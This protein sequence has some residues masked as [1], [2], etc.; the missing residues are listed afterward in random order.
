MVHLTKQEITQMKI[1][2][3]EKEIRDTPKHK[4]TEHHLGRLRARLSQLKDQEMEAGSKKGGGVGYSVKKQGD[5]TVVLV[6]SPSVGK[7]TLLNKLTNAKSKIA[8]YAFTTVTVIPGMMEY[9]EAKIQILDV[10]GL[11]EGAEAGKG[12]G[13]EV[14]SV[15]RNSDLLIILCDV[16]KTSS[17]DSITDSL[18]KAGVR[19]NKTPPNVSI[20][21]KLKGGIKI[22]SNLK[23]DIDNETIKQISKEFRFPNA[24]ITIKEKLTMESLIDSFTKSRVYIPAIY[25]VNKIDL[26]SKTN[27]KIDYETISISA[28]KDINLEKLKEEIWR[29]LKFVR[30]YLIRP[31]DKPNF[32]HP[33]IMKEEATLSDVADKIGE[34][35]S[36]DKKRAKIWGTGAKFSGQE[37]SLTKKV[38]EG[39]QVRLV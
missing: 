2:R 30:V 35:F 36:E 13:R 33:I 22:V 8:P 7:S 6:G 32:N 5:A 11:I 28:E 15:V 3:I 14:I 1:K 23:Q 29:K 21:K 17:F 37:V 34:E 25:A 18:E 38:A 12:R 4:A 9:K 20:E 26:S 19:L 16:D 10:P 24:D 27:K 39:M 31:D